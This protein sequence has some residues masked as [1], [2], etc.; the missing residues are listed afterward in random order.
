MAMEKEN[1]FRGVVI[2]LVL[3]LNFLLCPNALSGSKPE[4]NGSSLRQREQTIGSGP[5]YNEY[6]R[7]IAGMRNGQGALGSLEDRPAW[8]QYAGFF[9]QG[10][11][12]FDQKQLAVMRDWASSELGPAASSDLTVFYPF[13][14]PDFINPYTFFP[15]AK[16]YLLMALEPPGELPNFSAMNDRDIDSFFSTLQ[17]SLHDLLNVDYFIS[18]H[19]HEAMAS[20]DL[21]GVLPFFLFFMA[22]EN[23]RVL[24]VEYWCMKPDGTVREVPALD[25]GPIDEAGIPGVR[26]TFA[27]PGS[28]ETQTLYYFRLNAYNSSFGRNSHF[29]PF[30]RSFGPLTTFMKSAS[31]VMFDPNVSAARQLVL[32]Q[33]RYI[34]Q[35]DSGIPLKYFNPASWGLRFYGTYAEPIAIFKGK[36]QEDLAEI[37]KTRGDVKP[38]PF[39]IGYHYQINTSNLMFAVRK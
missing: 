13:S 39:A 4:A 22:R 27:G 18:A 10:W 9:D 38:L 5:A 31:F 15:H 37:Y 14:G 19:M 1:Q 26:I 8:I 34:L 28:P 3:F 23:I 25:R 33:S 21:K 30:L 35:E 17:R 32:D 2:F 29:G 36:H 12:K 6:A 20:K 7:F 16:T 24:D 11:K